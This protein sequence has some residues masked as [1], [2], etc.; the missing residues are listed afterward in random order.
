MPVYHNTTTYHAS[1]AA[2]MGSQPKCHKTSRSNVAAR[3]PRAM[4]AVCVRKKMPLH[5]KPPPA[6]QMPHVRRSALSNTTMPNHNSTIAL[7]NET[8]NT[9][10]SSRK[11]PDMCQ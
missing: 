3:K 9:A 7:N 8:A 2:M 11:L 5:S 6:S 4:M 10:V 1:G